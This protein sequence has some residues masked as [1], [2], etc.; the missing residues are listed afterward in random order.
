M[1]IKILQFINFFI[2]FILIFFTSLFVHSDELIIEIDNPKFTEKGLNDKVYEIKAKKGLKSENDLELFVIEGKFKS[3]ESGKWIY[4]EAEKGIFSQEKS[5]IK[6]EKNIIFY[7]DEG[8]EIKS[9]HAIF[10][11][12]NDV[13][14]L[15]EDVSHKNSKGL[16]LSDH[17]TITNNFNKIVYMGNVTS[18]LNKSN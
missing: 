6:L 10:D 15:Q 13:I 11:M 17:S 18:I 7:T 8:E 3:E 2:S 12:K 14:K 1:L 4:L 9:N 5:F 16:I